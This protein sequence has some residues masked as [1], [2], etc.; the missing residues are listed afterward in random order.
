LRRGLKLKEGHVGTESGTGNFRMRENKKGV[1]SIR[2][3]DGALGGDRKKGG[4]GGKGR[5][6]GSKELVECLMYA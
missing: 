4:A 1:L 6:V 5:Q 3:K 2:K